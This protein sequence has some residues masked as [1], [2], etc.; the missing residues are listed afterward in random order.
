MP[1]RE[2][3][4][5]RVG[6]KMETCEGGASDSM[7]DIPS[8]KVMDQC[9]QSH[10]L[11]W[12]QLLLIVFRDWCSLVC[13]CLPCMGPMYESLPPVEPTP[14][15]SDS[16]I[17]PWVDSGLVKHLVHQSSWTPLGWI[18]GKLQLLWMST[19]AS[20]EDRWRLQ[21]MCS[22]IGSLQDHIHLAEGVD[23]SGP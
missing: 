20:T 23:V 22:G 7:T 16:E 3:G 8:Y 13:R 5:L 19:G 17:T 10:I 9:R 1:L 21:V 2:R 6:G 15:G 4:R 18:K 14:K 12:N 11:H